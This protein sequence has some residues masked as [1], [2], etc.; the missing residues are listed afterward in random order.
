[1]TPLRQ[2]I[3]LHQP[4]AV[5]ARGP[6]GS[7][8]LALLTVTLITSLVLLWSLAQW[9]VDGLQRAVRNLQQRQRMQQET[10]AALGDLVPPGASPA[11]VESRIRQLRAEIEARERAVALL[12][13]GAIGRRSGFSAQLAALA[14]CPVTGLWLQRVAISGVTGSMS[15]AGDTEEPDSVPRYLRAL[16]GERALSGLRFDRLVIERRAP[17]DPKPAGNGRAPTP[18]GAFAFTA[19]GTPAG[20]AQVADADARVADAQ[21]AHP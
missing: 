13:Q 6:F 8:T 1:M 17:A 15:L 14:R 20:Y 5:G 18:R 7:G 21:G 9:R 19:D 11:D 12:Q 16:A 2:Q 3:N 4:E 10:I